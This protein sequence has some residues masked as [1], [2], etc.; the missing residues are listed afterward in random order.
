LVKWG[1]GT[2]SYEP[3]EQV[4]R[5]DPVTV[6]TY[7]KKHHLLDKPIWKHFKTRSF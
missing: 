6:A 5:D 2:Q 7:G 3:L 1:D 4:I